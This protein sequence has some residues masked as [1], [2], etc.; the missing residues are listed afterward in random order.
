MEKESGWLMAAIPAL[1]VLRAVMCRKD[2]YG[3]FVAGA[4]E[5]LQNAAHLIPALAAM[6][7]MMGLMRTSG[8]TELLTEA[9]SP[10]MKWL[11][12]PPETA[13][14]LLL[15]PLTGSGSLSALND[16]LLHYGADSR[17]G[18]AA[19]V[20]MGT[21]ETVFYTLTVYLTATDLKHLPWVVPVSLI[22]MLAGAAVTG[23]VV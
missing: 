19:S 18:N 16:L 1:I 10:A 15:R 2:A 7:L 17:I 9:V 12:L 22:S 8:M 13:T 5:G 14:V 23:I 6:M 11:N 20:L 3:A 21:T 4:G